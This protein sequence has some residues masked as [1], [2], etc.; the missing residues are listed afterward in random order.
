MSSPLSVAY[1]VT[2]Q[3]FQHNPTP[4][5][6]PFVWFN[7]VGVPG[8]VD[9]LGF[10]TQVIGVY[11]AVSDVYR[12]L[13]ELQPVPAFNDAANQD[14]ADA[15]MPQLL[16]QIT[17]EDIGA[18][19]HRASTS[20]SSCIELS[21][22]RVGI[23]IAVAYQYPIFYSTQKFTASLEIGNLV[24]VQFKE[25][26]PIHEIF[27]GLETL[28]QNPGIFAYHLCQRVNG[29]NDSVQLMY[30]PEGEL[31]KTLTLVAVPE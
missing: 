23:L 30:A 22:D 6:E 1:A 9:T 14:L 18:L 19:F 10:H 12:Y 15:F 25:P 4:D 28:G 2:L 29:I 7:C 20:G 11:N 26:L 27:D 21:I 31:S 13:T 5:S 3:I 8:W 16:A 24:A 17:K